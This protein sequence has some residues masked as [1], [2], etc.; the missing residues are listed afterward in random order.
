MTL[1]GLEISHEREL[2][3]LF[4]HYF[5]HIVL[6]GLQVVKRNQSISVGSLTLMNPKSDDFIRFLVSI[7][8]R[9]QH[10]LVNIGNVSKIEFV[11]EIDGGFFEPFGNGVVQQKCGSDNLIGLLED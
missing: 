10:S 2:G 4:L 1:V 6:I 9:K 7:G 5:K 11:V 3:E 8:L